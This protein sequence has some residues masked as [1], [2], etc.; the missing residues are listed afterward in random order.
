MS[1]SCFITRI[2]SPLGQ[3][4]G[5]SPWDHTIPFGDGC[6]EW[7]SKRGK[8]RQIS[9]AWFASREGILSTNKIWM[10]LKS[11]NSENTKQTLPSSFINTKSQRWTNWLQIHE[12]SSAFFDYTTEK[13]RDMGVCQIQRNNL[14]HWTILQ[15]K[16]HDYHMT[17]SSWNAT[18]VK[19]ESKGDLT[20]QGYWQIDQLVWWRVE[21]QRNSSLLSKI[22]R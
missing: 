12:L 16:K 5:L 13:W 9:A 7:I 4:K 22:S 19:L 6:V 10:P 20:Q 17:I 3:R 15:T 18:L 1:S 14:L 8:I 21:D 11:W 2:M